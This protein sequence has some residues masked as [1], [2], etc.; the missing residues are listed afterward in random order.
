LNCPGKIAPA[1]PF[2]F[3]DTVVSI[4]SHRDPLEKQANAFAGE[5]LVPTPDLENLVKSL[6]DRLRDIAVLDAAAR[7]FNVSRDAIFYRLTQRDF[8]DWSE[9]SSYFTG[10]FERRETPPYRVNETGELQDQID[11][12]FLQTALSLHQD[13]KISTGKLAEWLFAPRHIVDEY[14]ARLTQLEELAIS[15]EPNHEEDEALA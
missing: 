14:L 6:G 7:Y 10:G 9:K 11:P 8:F 2:S 12:I 4:A 1:K 3:R 15:D 13:E 5:F